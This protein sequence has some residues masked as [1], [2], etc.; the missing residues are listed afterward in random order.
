MN[1]V[2]QDWEKKLREIW[3][4]ELGKPR[5]VKTMIA[6]P[7]MGSLSTKF[8]GSLLA[9]HKPK[10]TAIYMESQS[11]IYDARNNLARTAIERGYDRVL[12]LDSDMVFE[13]DV[14]TRLN[15]RIDEGRD[16]V[17]GL[18]VQRTGKHRPT[19]YR[20]A[21]ITENKDGK[22]KVELPVYD[23]F[24]PGTIFEIA[25]CGFGICMTAVKML[26]EIMDQFGLPFTPITGFG[27][28][29]AFC[30]RAKEY[31]Y[32][33]WCDSSIQA[34]HEGSKVYTMADWKE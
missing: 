29:I 17:T 2:R 13:P 27:E 16:F 32:R 9:L 22:K 7:C 31:G 15:A 5:D 18:Y 12:W 1:N 8:T 19:I 33:L 34:G 10:G 20:D 6:I 11:L 25:A 21:R 26:K 3:K 24:E 14:L 28:D 30:A 4:K 23:D